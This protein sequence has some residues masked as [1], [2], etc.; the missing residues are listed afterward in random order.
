MAIANSFFRRL[1]L[2]STIQ[3]AGPGRINFEKSILK[4]QLRIIA[5]VIAIAAGA[6]TLHA[7]PKIGSIGFGLMLGEPTGIT[8][9]GS[10]QGN[11]A[12]DMAIGT[13]WF[14]N[15]TIQA[16]YLWNANVFNSNK[17]GLYFGVGGALGI[18]DGKGIVIKKDDDDEKKETAVGVRGVAGFNT[19]P[20]SSPIEFF[21]EI[22][23]ILSFAP[24]I[25]LNF[26]GAIG[27]RYYP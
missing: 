16:D 20:F 15:L 12:W 5:A 22:D 24:S 13:S 19:I 3:H 4:N 27:V 21:F 9:K 26:M 2:L 17:A 14:G 1:P 7:Q 10:L 25:G 18:G 11:N 23:P 6:A 8:L